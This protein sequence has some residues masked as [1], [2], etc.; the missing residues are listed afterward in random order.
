MFALGG[1]IALGFL[2]AR[3]ADPGALPAALARVVAALYPDAEIIKV[4]RDRDDGVVEYDIELRQRAGGQRV[5]IA[6]DEGTGITEVDEELSPDALPDALKQAMQR[7]FP[8]S[9]VQKA[10]RTATTK[11]QFEVDLLVDGRRHQ[12]TLSNKGKILEVDRK[13]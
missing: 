5:Q 11:Y 1:G 13:D 8:K 4:D 7:V 9:A 10:V 6:A 3:A 2:T 12:V